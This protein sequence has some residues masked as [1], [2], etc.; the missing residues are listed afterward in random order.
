M[1]PLFEQMLNG[2]L[3]RSGLDEEGLADYEKADPAWMSV[4]G[5]SRYWQ[6]HHPEALQ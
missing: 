6:K 1:V 5:L 3:E 4:A 2:D